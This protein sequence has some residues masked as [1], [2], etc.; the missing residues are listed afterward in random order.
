[1]EQLTAASKRYNTTGR[2][3]AEINPN[4]IHEEPPAKKLSFFEQILQL[5]SFSSK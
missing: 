5:F 4:S 2:D 3:I 1:M